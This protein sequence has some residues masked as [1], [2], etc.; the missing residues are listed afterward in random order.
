[1][2]TYKYKA[3]RSGKEYTA[4]VEAEDKLSLYKDLQT[5]GETV[6]SVEE[7]KKGSLGSLSFSFGKGIKVDDK[8]LF[9]K[10]LAAMIT[11][12]LPLARALTVLSR[13]T[14]SKNFKNI[15]ESIG[16]DLNKGTP[17]SQALKAHGDAFPPV[18]TAMVAA[19][20]ESGNMAGSLKIVGEQME[21]SH[22]LA[23]KVKGAMMYPTVI[24]IAMCIV[25]VL[26]FI[27][28]IPKLTETFKGFNVEL[29]WITRAIITSSDW[30]QAHLVLFL[31]LIFAFVF[32]VIFAFKS[33]P[34]KRFVDA[35]SIKLPV[36]GTM[37]KE[38][39]SA[40]ATRTLSSLLS[41][42]VDI[43]GSLAIASDVVQN[44]YYKEM[45][46]DLA[47]K[48]E[49][50]VELA[51]LFIAREDIYPIFV[52]EMIGVGEETGTLSNVLVEVATYYEGEV[53]QKTKDLSSIIE[54]IL[55]LTIGVAVGFF[56]IAM[57]SP[58][59]SLSDKI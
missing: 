24:L 55:M 34:G 6:L 25:G 41:S 15:L 21:K 19:G 57:I 9:A 29:P 35:V 59:Y 1:M 32:V 50:G 31:G 42:G 4:K 10:N 33:R 27:F 54:P 17:F 43:V 30:V 16:D 22:M 20:E 26:M 45:L 53:D 56:A 36:I 13:Q 3:V 5:K 12:G 39:N 49:K 8:I 58:I 47:N 40:R 46:K 48:V 18:M 7:I 28:V 38:V 44:H 51:P 37:I 23:K 52:G 11:A 14:R 2:A